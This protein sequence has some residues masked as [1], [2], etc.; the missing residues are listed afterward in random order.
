MF[1]DLVQK[2]FRKE[3]NFALTDAKKDVLVRDEYA[4]RREN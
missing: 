1:V 4:V 2:R 3:F